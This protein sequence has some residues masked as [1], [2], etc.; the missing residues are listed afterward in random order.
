MKLPR[1]CCRPGCARSAVATLT[2]VYAESTAVIGPLATSEEPHS[3]DLCDDHARRIT[4]PRGWEMLRSERGFSAPAEDHELTALAEA[5]REA[6]A[7]AGGARPGFVDRGPLG[8][9]SDRMPVDSLDAFDSRAR[10]EARAADAAYEAALADRRSGRH[11]AGPVDS[12]SQPPAV[13]GVPR[14]QTRPRPGRRGHL[15]VLPDPVD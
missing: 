8:R 13:P 3:W 4:V 5:V 9:G 7:V 15:R 12:P 10:D 6:G 11:R 2:F 1:L 14:H